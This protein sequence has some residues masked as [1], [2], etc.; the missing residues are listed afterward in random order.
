MQWFMQALTDAGRAD[1]AYAV[2]TQTTRPSWGYMV[3]KGATTSWERW[4]TDIQDGGMN[5][6]SQKILSGNLEAWLY[7]TLGGINY[8][9]EPRV[10]AHRVP[11]A[12]RRRLVL[13]QGLA[14]VAVWPDRQR[15]EDRRG[16]I[17]L[18][19][20]GSSQHDGDR[21]CTGEGCRGGD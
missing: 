8:D 4:D 10:Q 18:D 15:L 17:P 21:V 5:G 13:R 3:S 14:Q 20:G 19:H 1:V 16:R 11:P 12:A 9:P 2:A 6:E 7:Q